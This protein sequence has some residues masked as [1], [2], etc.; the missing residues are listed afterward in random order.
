MPTLKEAWEGMTDDLKPQ[1]QGTCGLY[2]FWYAT[3]LLAELGGTKGIVY[4]RECEGSTGGWE[5]SR[6]Y[7][8]R[9]VN[10]GQGEVMSEREMVT[11]V[12]HYGYKPH[13]YGSFFTD[14]RK[15][16]ITKHLN[17]N[18]PILIPYLMDKN[19]EA[20]TK[21][22]VYGVGGSQAGCGAHW[23]L[24]IAEQG[25]QYGYLEPND[26]LTI[27]WWNKDLLLASNACVDKVKYVQ[28]WRKPGPKRLAPLGDFWF[29]C[30]AK[31]AAGGDSLYDVGSKSRQSLDKVL[32]AVS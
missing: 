28:Y 11:I 4:P 26:P 5:S 17:A 18:Q 32:I 8:K 6:H 16:F 25:D 9:R 7:A 29:Q 1:R 22:A 27:T 24:I 14:K 20:V 15:A 21:R 31:K 12:K 30:N 23:S 13:C 19:P 10:S 3:Q 2:S